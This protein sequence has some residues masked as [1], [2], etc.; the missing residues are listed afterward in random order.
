MKSAF[1]VIVVGGGLAGLCSAIHLSKSKVSV[2]L[3]EKH[4]YPR[5]KVCGEYV[6]NEV[7]PYLNWLGF[8]PFDF[9]AKTISKFELTT[10]NNKRIS[11][12]LPLGGFGMSRH[13]MDYQL[14]IIARQKGTQLLKA[15]VEDIVFQADLDSFII[16]T[17]TGQNFNAKSVIGAFGKRSQLDLKLHRDF[18]KKRAPYLGVKVHVSGEFPEDMVA[19]HNFKGGYCGVSKIE[20][21]HIN[22]CYITNYKSFK[23]FKDIE[24][25]Q[26]QVMSKNSALNQIFNASELQFERPL[27][28][29]QISFETKKPVEQHIVMCGDTAGMIHPLCGN[30]MGMA[31]RSAQLA[32]ILIIDYL[33]GKIADRETMEQMYTEAWNR[34]FRVRLKI[35]QTIAYLFRQ[36]WLAPL[37]LAVL[38][39]FPFVLPRIIKQTHGEPMNVIYN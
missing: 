36:D 24:S 8:N 10:H 25:F 2:L 29:S 12:N 33:N 26:E 20:N 5:H 15:T 31:I 14:S 38:R 39:R 35:G 4:E 1:D 34:N 21:N 6:S 22:L 37:L 13:Q 30:G 9:G 17:K 18:I 19:L 11:A 28:I 32:S 7:L 23:K 16:T 3:L 27:T